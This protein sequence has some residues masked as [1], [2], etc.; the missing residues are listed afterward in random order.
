[1]TVTSF[2]AWLGPG[3]IGCLLTMIRPLACTRRWA[4]IDPAGRGGGRGVG[5]SVTAPATAAAGQVAGRGHPV[6]SCPCTH[7]D[8]EPGPACLPAMRM[9]STPGFSTG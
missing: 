2:P 4:R 5:V 8:P 7:G 6:H 3:F 1:M 9:G